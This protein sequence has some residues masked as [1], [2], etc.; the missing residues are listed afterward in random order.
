MNGNILVIPI[1]EKVFFTSNLIDSP[2]VQE[3]L[4]SPTNNGQSDLKKKK[5]YIG[6]FKESRYYQQC[7]DFCC[8]PR[9]SFEE[10]Y[11]IQRR[12]IYILSIGLCLSNHYF[13]ICKNN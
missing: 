12:N 9:K 3:M 10:V 5:N 4:K 6:S 7:C 8:S 1:K 13:S 2:I 11:N